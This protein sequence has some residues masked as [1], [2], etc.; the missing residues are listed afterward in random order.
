MAELPSKEIRL[1]LAEIK[2]I[3]MKRLNLALSEFKSMP[4][5][6]NQG[7]IDKNFVRDRMKRAAY[8]NEIEAIVS[9]LNELG[10]NLLPLDQD[11]DIDFESSSVSWGTAWMDQNPTGL[12][13][14]IFPNEVQVLWVLSPNA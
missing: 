11:N 4:V 3:I 13:L 7:A 5:E 6:P 8:F 14:E 10:H 12:D 1:L 9:E 2:S